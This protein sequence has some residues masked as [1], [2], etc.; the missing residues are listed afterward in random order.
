MSAGE[1]ENRAPKPRSAALGARPSISPVPFD[2]PEA[3]SSG[4]WGHA[5]A[6]GRPPVWPLFLIGFWLLCLG[7]LVG[8]RVPAVDAGYNCVGNVELWG[9]FGFELNCDSPEFMWLAREPEGLINHLNSRQSRPG[10]ILLAALIQAPLSLI[11][12]PAGEPTPV[13]QGLYDPARV[14]WSFFQ[15]R[16]AYLAYI[17]LNLAMLLASF[18]VLR[19]AIEH[20]HA[21]RYGAEAV[22]IVATGLLL[23][24]NDVTKAFVWSP[25]TQM[26]NILVPV[27]AVHATRRVIEDRHLDRKFAVAIG[28]VVGIGMTIYPFFVVIP[29]CMLLPVLIGMVR[30]RSARIRRRDLTNLALIGL[31]SVAPSALWYAFLRIAADQIFYAELDL[32]QVVWMKDA[33]ADGIGALLAQWFDY[34]GELL[35]MAAPQAIALAA[36][37]GWLAL[38]LVIAVRRRQI[39]LPELSAAVPMIAI[40]LYVSFAVLGFY[41]CVGWVTERLA[42]PAIPPLLFAVGATAILIARRL[43][44]GARSLL[45]GGCLA[46]AMAQIIY[47]VA[48]EGP[49][50]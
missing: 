43:P 3:A 37:V 20:R 40:G 5:K 15:D 38:S 35:E 4:L 11:V 17:L 46:I 33:L 50:S 31:L 6:V 29:A 44:T 49:W 16:P 34:L 48:K 36:L 21:V 26:L 7:L 47:E 28:L 30:T 32:K 41:T 9:P 23:V 2:R 10:L 13:Y 18:H 14:A 12:A 25:H 22:I 39:A 42:Y 27:L 19:R 8:P 1:L 45:A 24:A